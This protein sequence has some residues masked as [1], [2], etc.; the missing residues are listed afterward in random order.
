V[1]APRAQRPLLHAPLALAK[2]QRVPQAPQEVALPSEASQPLVALPS[3]SAKPAAQVTP[4]RPA[5]H[6]A[7]ALGPVGQVVPHAPQFVGSVET[8]VQRALVPQ[9]RSG[10]AQFAAHAPLEHTVPAGHTRPHW[11]QLA[12]SVRRSRQTLAHT[13]RPPPHE[14]S[15]TPATQ[16]CPAAQVVPQAPQFARSV[17]VSAQ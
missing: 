1:H 4:Q 8:S 6:T 3:Q 15:Q 17:R 12:L 16:S 2:S 13:E 14:S 11:P 9:A 10:V 5:A 7:V